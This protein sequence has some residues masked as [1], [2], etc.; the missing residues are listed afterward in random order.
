MKNCIS[1]QPLCKTRLVPVLG[2]SVLLPCHFLIGIKNNDRESGAQELLG[3]GVV[4]TGE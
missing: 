3:D 1:I 2:A 4:R